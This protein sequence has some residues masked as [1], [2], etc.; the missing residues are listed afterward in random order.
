MWSLS[1]HLIQLACMAMIVWGAQAFTRRAHRGR[2]SREA[3]RLR[4]A[5]NIGLSALHK[6]YQDNLAE[7]S[8][9]ERPLI[10]GRNQLNLLRTQLG[11]LTSLEPPEVE[12]VMA[13]SIAA[14]RA[15][16][17]MA[18]AGAKVG[19][20]AFRIP[21]K[22]AEV[23]AIVESALNDVSSALRSAQEIL[24]S[25]GM[26]RGADAADVSA[27]RETIAA[28]RSAVAQMPARTSQ[29]EPP[30]PEKAKVRGFSF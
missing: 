16:T 28:Q 4:S 15:E 22:N 5:L 3:R 21:K 18:I 7:L 19:G 11:R 6:L 30:Y 10:S 27:T 12:A 20:V 26:P 23:R 2:A 9:G 17:E 29:G 25:D 24:S 14:E 1:D 13:A 8:G